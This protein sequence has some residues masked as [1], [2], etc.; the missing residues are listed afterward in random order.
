MEPSLA[1][2]S[3]MYTV[4]LNTALLTPPLH[5]S[6]KLPTL[7]FHTLHHLNNVLANL[8]LARGVHA[9]PYSALQVHDREELVRQPGDDRAPTS[10]RHMAAAADDVLLQNLSACH[11]LYLLRL[12]PRRT[13]ANNQCR[14]RK[15]RTWSSSLK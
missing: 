1:L 15:L 8:R 14:H 6:L 12:A 4:A 5:L 7:L 10:R 2:G 3:Y 11:V 13:R 9:I